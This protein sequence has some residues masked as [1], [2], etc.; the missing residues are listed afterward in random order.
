MLNDRGYHYILVCASANISG[1]ECMC[2]KL[3]FD[4]WMD[5]GNAVM[6]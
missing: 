3:R 5:L 6:R 4:A 2:L 1:D